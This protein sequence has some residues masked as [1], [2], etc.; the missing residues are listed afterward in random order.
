[1]LGVTRQRGQLHEVQEASMNE[2]TEH[3]L[4]IPGFL[5]GNASITKRGEVACA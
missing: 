5:F 1:M 2:S 4:A 3:L